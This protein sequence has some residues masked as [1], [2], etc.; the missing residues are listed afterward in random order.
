MAIIG[1]NAALAV[2]QQ[3]TGVQIDPYLACRFFIEI[4]GLIAGSFAEVSGLNITTEVEIIR[5]GGVNDFAYV[6]PK[7]TSYS[8]IVLKRGVTNF[9]LIWQWYDDAINGNIKRKNGSI[10]LL[11]N[12]DL[13]VI[14]WNFYH[15]FPV[16]WDGPSF[17]AGTSSIATAS[18]S[19]AHQGLKRAGSGRA[20]L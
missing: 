1:S 4:E 12:A 3:L 18:L 6:L 9:D 15:A 5:E 13:P 8:N 20:I 16:Q 2:G 10:Y 19:L 17:D 7:T 14:W 11:D